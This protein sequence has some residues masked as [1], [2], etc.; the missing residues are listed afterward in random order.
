ML[1]SPPIAFPAI[2]FVPKKYFEVV[3]DVISVA[4][5]AAIASGEL[6]GLSY[7]DSVGKL[8]RVSH[9]DAPRLGWLQR[10]VN[11]TVTVLPSF[12]PALEDQLSSVADALCQI[13][14]ADRDDLYNQFVTHEEL[15]ALFLEADSPEALIQAALALGEGSESGS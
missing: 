3:T 5:P 6:E 9:I 7:F 1:S 4:T 11:P 14:D 8:W 10:L 15:K 12:E 13:V 2:V